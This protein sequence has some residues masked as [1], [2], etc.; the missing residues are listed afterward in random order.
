MELPNPSSFVFGKVMIWVSITL[1]VA[2]VSLGIWTYKLDADRKVAEA[3]KNATQSQLNAVIGQLEQNYEDYNRRLE[4][5]KQTKT[6]ITNQYYSTI[7]NID[8][9]GDVNETCDDAMR[10]IDAHQF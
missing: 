4:E 10:A 6:V 9:G 7:Q 2:L 1:T 5:S 8:K 3:D